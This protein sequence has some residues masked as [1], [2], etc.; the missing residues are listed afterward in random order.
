MKLRR[1]KDVSCPPITNSPLFVISLNI[2][3]TISRARHSEGGKIQEVFYRLKNLR[4]FIDACKTLRLPI[5]RPA[6]RREALRDGKEEVVRLWEMWRS[7]KT[8]KCK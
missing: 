2:I 3:R 8:V 7:E 4:A 5:V 1:G 6:Y